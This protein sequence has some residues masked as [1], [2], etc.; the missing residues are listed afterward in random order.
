MY[1][2]KLKFAS[3]FLLLVI[4]LAIAL[5][6]TAAADGGPIVPRDLW[7][8]LEEGHQ[9]G[10]V[11]IVD[12]DTASIDLFISILDNTGV[13]HEI[14][15]FVPIGNNT[16]LFNAQEENLFNFDQSTT[17]QLD[18]RLRAGV[19]R[20]Q[21]VIQA[22]FSGAL[23][24]NGAVLIPAWAPLLL[25]SCAA[26]AQQPESVITTESSEISIYNIDDNTDI[27]ALIETTGLPDAVAGT[28]EGLKGQRVA[29]VKLQT[30][31]AKVAINGDAAPYQTYSEPGLHLSWKTSPVIT[32]GGKTFTYPLGTGGAWASP[33]K[34]TR[35]YIDAPKGL[36]LNIQYPEL[37]TDHSGFDIISGA[38]ILDYTD[39][40]AFAVDETRDA[41]GRLWRAT[42]TQSN[43]AENV[44][45]KVKPE[46]ILNRLLVNME[47]GAFG[48]SILFAL[49]VGILVWVLAWQFLMPVFLRKNSNYRQLSWYEALIYPGINLVFLIIPG[50]IIYLVF[51]LG[52]TIPALMIQFLVSVGISTGVFMLIHRKRLGVSPGKAFGAFVLTSL[53]GS[54]AYLILAVGFAFLVGAI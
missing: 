13:S 47:N 33:I 12:E 45:I 10:V 6:S 19:T 11:T 21:H 30:Q 7:G 27:S 39:I 23:L 46:S 53:C 24:T 48:Y 51:L 1:A 26:G 2:N 49:I 22:L 15:F 54:A 18:R 9:I 40:P 14:T 3:L 8:D 41:A 52:L 31:T 20:R 37:G 28:L 17:N 5:P 29:I 50:A 38:R 32:D 16:S 44:I 35:V 25:T 36:D 42:Y 4:L 43:P 34:L